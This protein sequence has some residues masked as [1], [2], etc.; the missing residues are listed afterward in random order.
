MAKSERQKSES[1]YTKLM[2]KELS[3]Y[4]PM[5]AELDIG[6]EVLHEAARLGVRNGIL[7]HRESA[8]KH[9]ES[10][11]VAGSVRHFCDRIIVKTCLMAVNEQEM[12]IAEDV[13]M[14]LIEES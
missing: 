5:A 14:R 1:D 10:G 6:M 8:C 12:E 4:L 11:C 9:R 3:F 13:M 2:E 7:R